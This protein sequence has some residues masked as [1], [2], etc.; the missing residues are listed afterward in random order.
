[1]PDFPKPNDGFLHQ[2]LSSIEDHLEDESFGVA[3]L[4][5][6]VNMSRSNLL[7]RVKSSAGQS[8]SALIRQIRL[9]RAQLLLKEK[10]LTVSEVAFKVGFSSTSYFI[11]CYKEKFGYTPGEEG[12][13]QV[14]TPEKTN[15]RARRAFL[16]PFVWPVIT[17]LV[18]IGALVLL[19][20]Q[21][22]ETPTPS[23]EKTIAV[24][25]FTNDSDDQAN[26]YLINGLMSSVL[27]HLQKIEDLS[28]RSRTTVEQYRTGTKTI[29]TIAEE[30]GVSYVVEGSGQ[31]LGDE[32]LLSI[33]LIDARHDQ[34]IWSRRYQRQ[35]DDIFDLQK[36]V[37]TSIAQAIQAIITYDEQARIEEIPTQNTTA[38]D[39]YLRGLDKINEESKEGLLEGIELFEKA[40]KEDPNF[41]HPYAY[42]AVS[43]Y[44]LDLFQVEKLHGEDI[45]TYADKA[46]LLDED[47]PEGLIAKALYYMQDEQYHLALEF[48]EKV[49]RFYPHSAWTHN[50]LAHIY[51]TALP[52][53]RKYLE[54]AI[55][56]LRFTVANQDSSSRSMTYLT[57]ANA[58]AQ[59][60]FLSEAEPYLKK[61]LEYNPEN[62]YSELLGVFV[63]LGQDK[64]FRT[65]Q[66]RLVELYQRDTTR[67]DLLQEIGKVLCLQEDYEQAWYYY[68]KFLTLRSDLDL[69]IYNEQDINIAYVLLQLGKKE[70][71]QPYLD[72]YHQFAEAN[73]SLYREMLL[74]SYYSVLG[75]TDQ[76][77]NHLREFSKQS[78]F[79]YWLILFMDDDPALRNLI[80][81]PSYKA[82]VA[83]LHDNFWKAHKSL[84]QTLE[85]E[86]LI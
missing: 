59:N 39:Y 45:N 21:K 56:G 17:A 74:A 2:V 84:R 8:V 57:L 32:I 86:E 58:L 51:T 5:A 19:W 1:M 24:L 49:L 79:F 16:A 22:R 30:L 61:S 81:D 23:Y 36:E 9:E 46:I 27:D 80:A 15:P 7:R 72:N 20:F 28:V 69:D 83:R 12:K 63:T 11:R 60:G 73:T 26:S 29:P 13:Q 66:N 47:L 41:A 65:A 40:I 54:H 18:T 50:C 71:A 43:Y 48:F 52:D 33:S 55:R 3:E 78:G 85:K 64:D 25:P 53:S 10:D 37:A 76:G 62:P 31:R 38:Y 42:T 77:M 82:I 68:E 67:L 75:Q 6:K 70:A 14:P 44:Y 34:Q 35:V 4:A